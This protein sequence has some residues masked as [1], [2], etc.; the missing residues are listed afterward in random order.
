MYKLQGS[1]SQTG[2]DDSLTH[3]TSKYY[4]KKSSSLDVSRFFFFL[5]MEWFAAVSGWASASTH[6]HNTYQTS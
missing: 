6:I 4:S 2:V 3:H 5:T 1:T